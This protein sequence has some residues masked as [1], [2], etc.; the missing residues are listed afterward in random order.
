MRTQAVS[1]RE[2][3]G[4][5]VTDELHAALPLDEAAGANPQLDRLRMRRIARSYLRMGAVL[6]DIGAIA[7]AYLMA[8]LIWF[9]A[10]HPQALMILGVMLPAHVAVAAS[11]RSYGIASIVDARTGATNA[12]AAFL[13]TL[14]VVGLAVFFLKVGAEFSRATFGIGA[15]IALFLIPGARYLLA[16]ASRRT[17][18]NMPYNRVVISDGADVRAAPDEVV[19]DAAR[20]RIAPRLDDPTLLDRLG[21]MLEAADRVV[22]MC[23]PERRVQWA[24]LL[25]GTDVSAE[26]L[27]PELDTLGTLGVGSYEGRSTL[28]VAAAPLGVLDRALKRALD[29]TLTLAAMPVALPLMGLVALA[30]RLDSRGPILFAQERVGLGNRLFRMHKF[31]S[32]Y[33]DRLDSDGARST[34]RDDDRVTRVGRIIR[35]TSLDELPQ[36]FNVLSGAMSIVG[37]RPHALGSRAEDRLFWDIDPSYWHRHA[38]K[39]GLT[40]LAQVRGYRGATEKEEDLTN[41]LQA[42]LEYLS[43]WTIWRDLNIIAAT[44]RVLVH[45]NAF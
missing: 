41:R 44:F 9:G 37:P 35:A 17:L 32:M 36:L 18:G 42:D 5:H 22:V 20:A 4:A 33:V 24:A 6:G 26:V 13:V 27:A 28:V 23:P 38:V 3:A 34:G 12:I 2:L 29:L 21:R 30:V 39:P 14:S 8:T 40:G 45:R 25:R 43:G 7:A 31:R 11:R 1:S 19:L 15:V 10:L 16:A